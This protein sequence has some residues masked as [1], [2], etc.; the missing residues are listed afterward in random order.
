MKTPLLKRDARAWSRPA[1]LAALCGL[2]LPVAASGCSGEPA[3]TGP[4]AI[5]TSQGTWDRT[6]EEQ[7]D[8]LFTID[9]SGGMG[10]AQ[11][12]LAQ[13]IPQLM[14]RLLN[15][16]CKDAEGTPAAT[17]PAGPFDPCPAGGYRERT[18]FKDVHVG[19]I[20]TSLGGHG[21]SFCSREG[22]PSN[23][24]RGHLLARSAHT[25]L[26]ND[27]AEKTYEGKGFL[28]WD[29]AQKLGRSPF[30]TGPGDGEA[31]LEVDSAGDGNVTALIPVLTDL[32]QGVGVSGCGFESQLESWYRFLVDPEPYETIPVIDGEAVP[33]GLDEA[34]LQQRADFL[35]PGS[36]VMIVLLSEENDCSIREGGRAY[37]VAHGGVVDNQHITMPRPRSECASD[38][39]DPCCASCAQSPAACPMDPT[40]FVNGDPAQGV[41]HLVHFLSDHPNL[42]CFDQKRRFG[43]DYL[44]PISRYHQAL[45]SPTI[46]NRAG[47]IVA[48]PLFLDLD[49]ADAEMGVRSAQNIFFTGIVG[50]PW[51]DLARD[52]ADLSQGLKNAEELARKGSDGR[53]TW[54]IVVGDPAMREAPADPFMRESTT[55]R[56]GA[57]PITGDAVTPPGTMTLNPINGSERADRGDDLQFACAF[58]LAEPVDCK[59][60]LP[61]CTCPP[62][63]DSP[64]CAPNPA[65]GGERT[66]RVK[67]S[68][69]PGLRQLELLKALG[70]QGITASICPAQLTDAGRADFGF[71]PVVQAILDRMTVIYESSGCLA[72]KLAQEPDGHVSCAVIEARSGLSSP[73]A[74]TCTKARGRVFLSPALEEA[75][76][77]PWAPGQAPSGTPEFNC[78]C[79]IEQLEGEA[80]AAC[81]S[82]AVEPVQTPDGEVLHG[83]CYVDAEQGVGSPEVVQKTLDACAPYQSW[84]IR[85]VGNG[86]PVEPSYLFVACEGG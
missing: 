49:P 12:L 40:C 38:P 84:Q 66:L 52:P 47:E 65:D 17:Q 76:V 19:V 18:R 81:Q 86:A 77:L 43:V 3:P 55:P 37:L 34:L 71:T 74:C 16:P 10:D 23:D 4:F 64:L 24:D 25:G 78:F 29:P 67:G 13:A 50:V 1:R 83:W 21:G 8:L 22:S 2:A 61:G 51:Q 30:V 41:A 70:D 14:T 62:D 32:V 57:N 26:G 46:Q 27:L 56:S 44:Y 42:R 5:I 82:D 31:D 9:N 73:E 28:A 15:P 63:N 39:D 35:R 85:F 68:A 58:D 45:T 59:T 6:S 60:G 79:E 48:N 7:L 72:P 20:S 54:D 53:T 11:Q 80:L 36:T 33:Q 75:A 69:Y